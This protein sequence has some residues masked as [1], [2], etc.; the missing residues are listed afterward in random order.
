[1]MTLAEI[2][3][4]TPFLDHKRFLKVRMVFEITFDPSFSLFLRGGGMT[5]RTVIVLGPEADRENDIGDFH[6]ITF[7]SNLGWTTYSLSPSRRR[8]IINTGYG[9]LSVAFPGRA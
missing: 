9:P 5:F 1:M 2:T 3:V 6:M 4:C 7:T 8:R